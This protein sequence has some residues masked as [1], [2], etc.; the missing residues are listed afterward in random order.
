LTDIRDFA[1]ASRQAIDPGRD[2]ISATDRIFADG[3]TEEMRRSQQDPQKD[4]IGLVRIN[5]EVRGV[6]KPSLAMTVGGGDRQSTRMAL[7]NAKKPSQSSETFVNATS[8]TAATADL[9]LL[10]TAQAKTAGKK[11]NLGPPHS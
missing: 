10:P 6:Y 11:K 3:T 4:E 5:L 8:V 7:T 9:N 1:P 2:G